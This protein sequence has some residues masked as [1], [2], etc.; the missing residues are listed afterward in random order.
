VSRVLVARCA[1]T[2]RSLYD[3][4]YQAR[5]SAWDAADPG[6]YT[7]AAWQVEDADGSVR[8][9]ASRD[10]AECALCREDGAS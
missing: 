8:L 3:I 2:G 4:R 5:G 6:G 7:A 9:Y 10:T 1:A